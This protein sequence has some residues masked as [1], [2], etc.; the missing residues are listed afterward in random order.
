MDDTQSETVKVTSDVG[1]TSLPAVTASLQMLTVN[2]NSPSSEKRRILRR[3]LK[4]DSNENLNRRCSLRP[5]KIIS[6]EVGSNST[7]KKGKETEAK[8]QEYYLNRNLKRKLNNLETIYE[9]KDDINECST[10]MS[11]KRYKR[12][13]QF[14]ENSSS[15]KLKKRR[16]R[17]KRVFGS[18]INFKRRCASMQVLLDKLSGIRAES[19]TKVDS[20]VK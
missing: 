3:V 4:D 6:P 18:K 10:Y 16:A 2:T 14:Q 11:A 13:I 17:I 5:K 9:E 8:P 19:P 15:S 7:K 20:E 12:M 1:D